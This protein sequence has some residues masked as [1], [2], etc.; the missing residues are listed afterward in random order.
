M[1]IN[2]LL[3]TAIYRNHDTSKALITT[4]PSYRKTNQAN[5]KS[6]EDSF[7]GYLRTLD[8]GPS[9]IK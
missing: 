1:F 6:T 8:F 3:I 5:D 9:N 4:S 2:V 7:Q